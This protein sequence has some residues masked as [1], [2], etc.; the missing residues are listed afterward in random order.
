MLM[1]AGREARAENVWAELVF[2][3]RLREDIIRPVYTDM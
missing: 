3:P 2:Y 1:T